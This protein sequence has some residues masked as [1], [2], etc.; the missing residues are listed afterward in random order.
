[1][2]NYDEL[3]SRLATAAE[4]KGRIK[5]RNRVLAILVRYKKAGWL[6][7]ALTLLLTD[8]ICVED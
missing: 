4:E 1:M 8:D 6:D 7:D 5:E 2:N 3:I